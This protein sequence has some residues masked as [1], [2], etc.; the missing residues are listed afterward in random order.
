MKRKKRLSKKELRA[1]DEFQSAFMEFWEKYGKKYWKQFIVILIIIIAVPVAISLYSYYNNKKETDA[2]NE[3]NQIV[4]KFL[5]TKNPMLLENFLKK[6][7]GTKANILAHIRLANFYFNK[8]KYQKALKIYKFLEKKNINKEFK[9][10]AKLCEAQCLLQINKTKE[11]ENILN[12]L[13]NDEVVGAEATLYLAFLNEKNPQK[14]K[15][16]YQEILDRYQGFIFYNYA[17]DKINH[18]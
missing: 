4:S 10:F 6:Y 15:Q 18:L 11:A 17:E 14:A 8:G 7:K 1:P 5:K 12:S 2:F 9:N 3:Y 13:K 16:L